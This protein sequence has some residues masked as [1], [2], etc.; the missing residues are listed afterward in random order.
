MNKRWLILASALLALINCRRGEQLLRAKDCS[1][2]LR[3][4]PASTSRAEV[5]GWMMHS[6]LCVSKVNLVRKN[7]QLIVSV[8]AV[9]ADGVSS[10]SSQF[11]TPIELSPG[12]HEVWFG[13]P[14]GVTLFADRAWHFG[15]KESSS[16]ADHGTL[17]WRR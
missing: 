10:C 15:G 9:P 11:S 8:R 2:T 7:A 1:V 3:Q 6:G 5:S 17:L 14:P 13:P 12:I 4:D 16:D